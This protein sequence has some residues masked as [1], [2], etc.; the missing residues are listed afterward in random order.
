MKWHRGLAD[1]WNDVG[2]VPPGPDVILD[3]VDVVGEGLDRG[4][5]VREEASSTAW[6]YGVVDVVVDLDSTR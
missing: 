4:H 2:A 3:D 1:S 6:I 5:V